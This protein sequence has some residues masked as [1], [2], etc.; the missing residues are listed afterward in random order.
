MMADTSIPKRIFLAE[1]DEDDRLLFNEA[2]SIVSESALLTQAKNGLELMKNLHNV[3]SPDIIFLDL[4]MPLKN[5]YECLEE[6][7][8]DKQSLRN[9]PIVVFTTS[10]NEKNIDAAYELG[11]SY[12]A[13]KPDNFDKLKKVIRKAIESLPLQR[14]SRK[15]FVLTV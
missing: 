11:A 13:I 2:L 8:K 6:I 9:L 10:S 4:N 15:D 12:Y 3:A 14:P 7:R 5:G 1:D